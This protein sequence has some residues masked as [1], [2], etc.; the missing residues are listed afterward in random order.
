MRET[1][2]PLIGLTGRDYSQLMRKT[3]FT[4]ERGVENGPLTPDTRGLRCPK[5]FA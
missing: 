4:L 1:L 5:I 2:V 3:G